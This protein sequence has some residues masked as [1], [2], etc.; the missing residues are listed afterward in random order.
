[1]AGALTIIAISIAILILLLL[2]FREIVLWYTKV[3]E[4]IAL[5]KETNRLLRKL[6]GEKKLKAS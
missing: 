4:R 3:N 2:I 6:A 5:Q 1:M